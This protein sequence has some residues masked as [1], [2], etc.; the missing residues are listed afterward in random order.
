MLASHRVNLRDLVT[1]RFG[2]DGF[3]EAYQ[4]HKAGVGLK[5]LI[6]P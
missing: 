5:L 4:L 3:G 1:H 6:E 2:L